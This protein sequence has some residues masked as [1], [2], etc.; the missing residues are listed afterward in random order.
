MMSTPARRRRP[1][2]PD[3][4]ANPTPSQAQTQT[5]Q[6]T[7]GLKALNNIYEEPLL[8]L[9]PD[10]MDALASLLNNKPESR[11]LKFHLEKLATNLSETAG[12]I[13]ERYAH[14]LSSHQRKKKKFESAGRELPEEDEETMRAVEERAEKDTSLLD[15][16]MRS[17]VDIGFAVEGLE[18]GLNSMGMTL[19]EQMAAARPRRATRTQRS[20]RKR[21][22]QPADDDDSNEDSNSEDDEDEQDEE[23]E[24]DEAEPTQ[25]G[26]GPRALLEQGIQSDQT[27]WTTQSLTKRYAQN[28]AYK[29]FFRNVFDARH[30]QDDEAPPLPHASTWFPDDNTASNGNADGGLSDEES[31]LQVAKE[32]IS[33]KCPITLQ[34]FVQPVT[35]TKCPHSFEKEAI[36][37]MIRQAK[38]RTK[39]PMCNQ[40]LGLKDLRP[41]MVLLRRMRAMKAREEEDVEDDED[42]GNGDLQ[43]EDRKGKSRPSLQM[44]GSQRAAGAR[45]KRERAGTVPVEVIPATQVEEQD[46][47]EDDE[48]EDEDESD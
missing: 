29:D 11:T 2:G 47:G 22:R 28:N 18:A 5:Q 44:V 10:A 34:T 20:M 38:G 16:K 17:C 46:D 31:E 1:P 9:T 15:G 24:D 27:R 13:N 42:A 12:N 23:E 35:S 43:E 48:D 37:Q 45:V 3:S 36:E 30:S 7:S 32:K 41:D 33:F 39:C 4:S 8:P 40:W 19:R 21:R 26:P 6:R 25:T 14:A